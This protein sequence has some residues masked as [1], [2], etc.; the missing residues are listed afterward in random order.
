MERISFNE[1]SLWDVV[2]ILVFISGH[3]FE[4]E[5]QPII[6]VR[7]LNIYPL[8]HLLSFK[9]VVSYKEVEGFFSFLYEGLLFFFLFVLVVFFLAGGSRKVNTSGYK[10]EKLFSGF[11]EYICVQDTIE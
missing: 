8:L 6:R 5:K 2:M 1:I 11:L 7:C 9:V 10:V 4:Y 3:L